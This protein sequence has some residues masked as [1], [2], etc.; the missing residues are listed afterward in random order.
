VKLGKSKRLLFLCA[1]L[2]FTCAAVIFC[3]LKCAADP[4]SST[5]KAICTRLESSVFSIAGHKARLSN[6][7]AYGGTKRTPIAA[8]DDALNRWSFSVDNCSVGDL[9]GDGHKDAAVLFSY[10]GATSKDDDSQYTTM[11]LAVML[12]KNGHFVQ[13]GD[14]TL[15]QAGNFNLDEMIVKDGVV[16][17]RVSVYLQDQDKSIKFEC[18]FKVVGD[19]LVCISRIPKEAK[20]AGY[21]L[22]A[23]PRLTANA[24]DVILPPTN[25]ETWP[26]FQS[27]DPSDMGVS[28]V[29]N[30]TEKILGN[31]CYA[32]METES[33]RTQMKDGQFPAKSLSKMPNKETTVGNVVLT[34]GYDFEV[35]VDDVCF[36][37][38]NGDGRKDAAV[39]LAAPMGADG[40]GYELAPVVNDK[41]GKLTQFGHVFLGRAIRFV[42]MKIDAGIITVHVKVHGPDDGVVAPTQPVTWRFRIAN[43]RLIKLR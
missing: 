38:L 21:V 30:L 4:L 23:A 3:P 42:G 2:I 20:P 41:N 11:H 27:R 31:A 34:N 28:N 37:D 24:Q 32:T 18:R 13:V 14:I 17:L 39:L 33:N 12:N 7:A 22:T 16:V 29:T 1:G 9:N 15:T 25:P 35:K 26:D 5:D 8:D 19:N 6:G 36:G 43:G 40:F 10:L